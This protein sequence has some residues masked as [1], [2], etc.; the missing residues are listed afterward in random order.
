MTVVHVDTPSRLHFGLID[1]N[2]DIGRIDGSIGLAI[3]DPGF[4]LTARASDETVVLGAGVHENRVR[5]TVTRLQD[6]WDVGGAEFRFARTIPLHS[7]LGAGTQLI[8]AVMHSLG[9]LY[10]IT[11]AQ[12]DVM[13]LSGR[14]GA[15]G[16]GLHAFLEGGFIVDGGH[17]FPG[18]KQSYLPSA[19]STDAGVGPL[20]LR[21]EFPNWDILLMIPAGRHISGEEEVRLF[22]G[23]CPMP[24]EAAMHI[25]H[26]LV[27]GMLPALAERD[28]PTFGRSLEQS[29]SVGWKQ[30]EI[31]AQ[32]EVVHRT[33]AFARDSGAHGAAMSS[34]GPATAVFVD[35][36]EDL[37]PEADA[38][39]ESLPNGGVCLVT[40][41]NNIGARI[42]VDDT[43]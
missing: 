22:Q 1:L 14:G 6:A 42:V 29:Q 12:D 25:C 4:S 23:L 27:M 11:L 26:A 33:L 41:A 40:K 28:L 32:G 24:P 43:A 17:G 38:F 8:L 30:V 10:G 21:Q 18:R 3:D 9:R 19:A 31:D 37:K 2:G 16:I 36:A 20:L 15:S 5:A 35:D 13:R 39:L 34:W 7:G